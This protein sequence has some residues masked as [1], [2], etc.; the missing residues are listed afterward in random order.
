MF[1]REDVADACRRWGGM[2]WLPP[3]VDGVKLL[4]AISG[5]ESSFGANCAPR[6][7]PYYQHLA[8]S[9][10]NGQL[11]KLMALYGS[12]AWSSFGPW[13]E[14]LVNCSP[15]MQPEDFANLSRC[16]MEVV[17]FI[18]HRILQA[19]KA[20][21]V[22]EIAEA[23]NSGKWA[24]LEVPPGVERYAAQCRG[25]YDTAAMPAEVAS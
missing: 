10:K 6:Q 25:Y 12:A 21:G 4:W 17:S 11:S 20:Q 8:Q 19:E 13:Q 18:N 22:E 3:T 24:W 15:L 23:Y 2:L 9:G 14:L 5:C 7:E 16:A 1:A